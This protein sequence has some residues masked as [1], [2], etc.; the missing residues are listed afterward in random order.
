MMGA[1]GSGVSV[2]SLSGVAVASFTVVGLGG[3]AV[4]VASLT[5]AS[6][7]VAA[8]TDVALA[9]SRATGVDTSACVA[10]EEGVK[11]GGIAAGTDAWRAKRTRPPAATSPRT[12][13]R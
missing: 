3:M 10:G 11:E 4:T 12:P 13:D 8:L 5:V 7:A 2:A 1:I 9:R 6:L